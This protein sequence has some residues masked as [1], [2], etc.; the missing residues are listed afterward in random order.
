MR[1][2]RELY[3]NVL[4]RTGMMNPLILGDLYPI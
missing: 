2:L 4:L 3:A 1:K